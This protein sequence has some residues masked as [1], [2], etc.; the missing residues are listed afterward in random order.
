MQSSY[1][2]NSFFNCVN[3]L[4]K[5]FSILTIEIF[6]E[7]HF[8]SHFKSLEAHLKFDYQ[9]F[10]EKSA[11]STLAVRSS[12]LK[13]LKCLQSVWLYK[14]WCKC[15]NLPIFVCFITKF[16]IVIVQYHFTFD[17]EVF[18]K[19]GCVKMCLDQVLKISKD[20]ILSIKVPSSNRPSLRF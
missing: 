9:N 13:C 10:Q 15:K 1:Q 6:Q 12:L 19:E 11:Q 20:F 18:Y 17:C 14:V 4:S 3:P 5:C 7:N 2:E 8:S 16:L